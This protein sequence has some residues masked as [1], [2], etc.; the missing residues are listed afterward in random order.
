MQV[1]DLRKTSQNH[2]LLGLETLSFVEARLG[3]GMQLMRD[4]C[5][6]FTSIIHGPSRWQVHCPKTS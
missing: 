2:P 1:G 4:C 6:R 5:P 3:V